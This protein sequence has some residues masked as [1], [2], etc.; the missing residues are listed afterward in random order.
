MLST[1]ER[2]PVGESTGTGALLPFRNRLQIDPIALGQCP[3]T[4]RASL[5]RAPDNP[6]RRGASVQ[7]LAHSA[8]FHSD[9]EIAPS[10][11]GIKQLG[12]HTIGWAPSRW[13]PVN[14]STTLK[15]LGSEK[16]TRMPMACCAVFPKSNEII[17]LHP[18]RLGSGSAGCRHE[19]LES[20]WLLGASL[21]L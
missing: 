4:V 15:A 14:Y 11:L 8:F 7:Y 13:A 10:K 1:V 2:G 18:A 16:A 21:C 9:D 19:A 20:F 6:R 12:L 3:R 17:R 5:D